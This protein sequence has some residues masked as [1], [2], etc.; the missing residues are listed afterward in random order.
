M[1]GTTVDENNVV[2]KTVQKA[3]NEAGF[4]LSLV[5]VL[6]QGAGKE[7]LQAIKDVLSSYADNH[8]EEL[9]KNIYQN[10]ITQL[11]EA[12]RTLEILPQ[13]NAE[14]LFAALR[15]RNIITIL[16]TGY[17]RQT[18]QTIIDKLQWKKGVDFDELVTA[19]EVTQNRPNP[20]M[21]IHAM[22]EF[23]IIDGKSVA[24]VGDSTIDIEEGRNAGC[25]LCIGITTGAHTR[26]QLASANPDHIINNLVELVA[27]I[28]AEG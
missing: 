10:F 17:D 8:D 15:K 7:K 18:A 5:Q 6:A 26:E 22:N 20:D 23:G 21:I 13:P 27:L 2:Y 24:K 19:T 14:K 1:A 9:A 16:N 3:I 11:G 4:D 28:D 25:S 12:Y